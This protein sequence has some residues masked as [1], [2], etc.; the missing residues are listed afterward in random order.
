MKPSD[1][2]CG[3][4]AKILSIVEKYGYTNPRIFGSTAYG[5][6]K[7]ESDLDILVERSSNRGS[8]LKLVHLQIELSELLGVPV[9]IKTE[10]MIP[11]H[12]RSQVVEESVGL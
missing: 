3:N 5:K 12:S 4:E 11:E 6:D 9:D 2:L 8:M 1:A 10:K 7:E